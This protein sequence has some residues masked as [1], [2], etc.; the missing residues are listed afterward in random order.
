MELE[1]TTTPSGTIDEATRLAASNRQ[2]TLNPMHDDVI[3]EDEPDDLI[4][5]KHILEPPIANITTDTE[6][7]VA[8]AVA[9]QEKANHHIALASSVAVMAI[10]GT[11][12]VLSF[13]AKR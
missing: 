13:L 11:I 2:L 4:A 5:S 3:A 10:V 7:T 8:V 6:A 12:T 1:Q 9:R